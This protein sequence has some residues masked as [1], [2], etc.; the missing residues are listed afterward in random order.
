MN[1]ALRVSL[2]ALIL[3]ATRIA[4]VEPNPDAAIDRLAGEPVTRLE[5]GLDR[6]RRALLEI[7]AIDPL[8]LEPS[9][10]PYF[11]NA[12]FEAGYISIEIGRTLPSVAKDEA[13]SLCTEYITRVRG[14]LSV[15]K[16]GVPVVNGVSDLA[17][18]YFHPLLATTPPDPAFARAL[19]SSVRV[20]A[21]VAAPLSGVYAICTAK[22]TDSPIRHID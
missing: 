22:L 13:R 1:I 19:D 8:T 10:P 9:T 12:D 11:I 15:G 21:L 20:R 6:L 4:A 2:L 5:W 17:A 18:E 14:F 16:T 3:S 7:F